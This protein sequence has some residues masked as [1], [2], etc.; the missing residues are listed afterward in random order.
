MEDTPNIRKKEEFEAFIGALEGSSVAHWKDIAEA[1]GVDKDTIT[2]WKK[3]PRARE[4]RIKGIQYAFTQ[5]EHAGKND[6]RMWETKLKML[7]INKDNVKEYADPEEGEGIKK[8]E[9]IVDQML[10]IY[11]GIHEK[12]DESTSQANQVLG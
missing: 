9:Q 4:T 7:G 12:E 3:H 6:W 11:E 1:V 8:I 5:M 10:G 2:E